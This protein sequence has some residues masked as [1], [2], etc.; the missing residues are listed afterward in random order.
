LEGRA[1]T[2]TQA[3]D[4]R[5]HVRKVNPST[6]IDADAL[7]DLASERMSAP[8]PLERSPWSLELMDL[9]PT[10]SALLVRIHFRCHLPRHAVIEEPAGFGHCPHFDD[11]AR[12]AARLVAFAKTA[13]GGNLGTPIAL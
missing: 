13:S 5:A 1:G 4:L 7:V 6:P 9:G 2:R 10:G 12:L 3:F 11:P 8:L